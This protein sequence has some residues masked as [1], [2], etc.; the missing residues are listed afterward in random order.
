M[1]SSTEVAALLTQR[2]M[3]SRYAKR[4]LMS[5]PEFSANLW[6]RVVNTERRRP[7]QNSPNNMK[8]LALLGLLRP[9]HCQQT[10]QKQ[11]HL[12][13]VVPLVTEHSSGSVGWSA[14]RSNGTEL[15][16]DAAAMVF[17]PTTYIKSSTNDHICYSPNGILRKKSERP[18]TGL[19]IGGLRSREP[20]MNAFHPTSWSSLTNFECFIERKHSFFNG[21]MLLK[22]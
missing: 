3:T 2:I 7:M 17:V 8:L 20:L 11:S 21:A 5:N 15:L 22:N 18:R 6:L 19:C 4:H 10:A 1:P 16:M 14:Q 13:S 9:P 12:L